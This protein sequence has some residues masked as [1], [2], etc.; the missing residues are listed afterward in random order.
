MQL[1]ENRFCPRCGDARKWGMGLHSHT[2]QTRGG[3]TLKI[4]HIKFVNQPLQVP[5][6]MA[7]LL[8]NGRAQTLET[9]D[10]LRAVPLA[11]S[12]D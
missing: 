8:V 11:D 2:L 12:I 9:L 5:Q 6:L 10:E 7:S 4:T 3:A 1:A